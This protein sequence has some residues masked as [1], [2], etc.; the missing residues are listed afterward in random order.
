MDGQAGVIGIL[1]NLLTLIGIQLDF[2]LTGAMERKDGHQK[3]PLDKVVT[4]SMLGLNGMSILSDVKPRMY[5]VRRVTG[6]N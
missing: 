6:E 1:L 3:E 2:I 4:M 5:W